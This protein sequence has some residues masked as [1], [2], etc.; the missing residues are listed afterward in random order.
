M[1]QD[2]APNQAPQLSRGVS[3]CP[4][5]LTCVL[6]VTLTPSLS[7]KILKT[8][9]L[10]RPRQRVAQF[11]CVSLTHTGDQQVNKPLLGGAGFLLVNLL[12]QGSGLRTQKGKRKIIFP[13]LQL[14]LDLIMR[15]K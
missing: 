8:K 6:S 7:K 5:S 15:K 2:L 9:K 10:V 3:L 14:P 11:P 13:P 4:P 12:L 1:S